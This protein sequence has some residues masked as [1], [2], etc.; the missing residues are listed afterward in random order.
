MTDLRLI[1]STSGRLT[2]RVLPYLPGTIVGGT[3]VFVSQL[4]TVYTISVDIA[5]IV[6]GLQPLDGDLTAI[7]GLSTNGFPER[8]G[9]A[10]WQ[11]TSFTGTGSVVRAT[12]PTLG[13][14]N[15]TQGVLTLAGPPSGS[16][17]GKIVLNTIGA[18]TRHTEFFTG[19]WGESFNVAL[20][21]FRSSVSGPVALDLC[22]N[23]SPAISGIDICSTDVTADIANFEALEINK[24]TTNAH[25]GT[26]KAGTGTVRNLDIQKNGGDLILASSGAASI[27]DI[28]AAGAGQIKFPAT[29]NASA[30]ANTLDDYEEG[31]FTPTLTFQTPGNLNVVYDIRVGAYTK[32][33]RLVI[34]SYFVRTTTFTHTTATGVSQISGFPFTSANVANQDAYGAAG[35]QG[36][37]KANYTDLLGGLAANSSTMFFT[38]SGS[39]QAIAIVAFGDMPTGG[40]VRY[41]GTLSYVT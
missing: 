26:K 16:F 11:I 2:A 32:I 12:S 28:S 38:I 10:T 23:G 25:V 13:A 24:S 15:V 9:A 30:D 29:Q 6:A 40:T 39:G 22:P 17:G 35:W 41:S 1:L 31:T 37:T 36:I 7:A 34:A 19:G 3:A 8:T 18:G 14:Q 27:F 21:V 5:A 20:G 33:G 4:G